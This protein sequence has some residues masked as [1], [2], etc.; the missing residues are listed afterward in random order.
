MKTLELTLA[1]ALSLVRKHRPMITPNKG[2]M[3]Q[4]ELFEQMDYNMDPTNMTFRTYRL[5]LLSKQI[6]TGSIT[7]FL[8]PKGPLLNRRTIFYFFIFLFLPKICLKIV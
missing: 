2:F 8:W 1:D 7:G 4:L 3:K 5:G 6:L